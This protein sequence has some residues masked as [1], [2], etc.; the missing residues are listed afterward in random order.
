MDAADRALAALEDLEP[1]DQLASTGWVVVA[2]FGALR[3]R[4]ERTPEKREAFDLL[5]SDVQAWL[6]RKIEVLRFMDAR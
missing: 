1:D 4:F 6:R 3:P 5:C 2:V